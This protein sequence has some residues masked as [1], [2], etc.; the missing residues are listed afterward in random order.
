MFGGDLEDG[1]PS[2][3]SDMTDP[4]YAVDISYNVS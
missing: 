4:D 3:C 2:G 1:T